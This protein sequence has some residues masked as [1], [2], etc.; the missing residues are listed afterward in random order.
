MTNQKLISILQSRISK[1][2]YYLTTSWQLYE[3]VKAEQDFLRAHYW[4][5]AVNLV[6]KQQQEDKAIMRA[7]IEAERMWNNITIGGL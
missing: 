1:R 3:K 4:K 5:K 6:S 2:K 7:L